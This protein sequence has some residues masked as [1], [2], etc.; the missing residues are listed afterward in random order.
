MGG[1]VVIYPHA[2]LVSEL[3]G[4][5]LKTIHPVVLVQFIFPRRQIDQLIKE[6]EVCI[7]EDGSNEPKHVVSVHL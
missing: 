7:P 1:G 6:I 5:D 3:D 4:R 2:L